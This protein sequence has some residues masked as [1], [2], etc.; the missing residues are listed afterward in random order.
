M[1]AEYYRLAEKIREL[2]Q[3]HQKPRFLVSIAGPPGSGKTTT[4]QMV[5][6]LLNQSSSSQ[7]ALISLDGFHLPRAA[8]D[9]FP[10]PILAHARRGSPWTFD[11]PRFAEFARR[12]HNWAHKTPL[13]TSRGW[14]D[15]EVLKA[16]T[17]DHVVKDPIEDGFTITPDTLIIILEGSYLLLD[18]PGWKEITDLF[19]YRIF[20]EVD[21]QEARTRVAK[22]HVHTGIEPTLEEGYRRMDGNDY[23]NALLIHEKLLS[24]DMTLKSIPWGTK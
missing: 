5:A 16:P 10:D 24:P 6:N 17:F 1:D 18:E 9:Q 14:S 12:L 15:D 11:L 7:T 8:L 2:A 4:A 21:L 23:S 3:V 22:R 13:Y 19:D 20:I